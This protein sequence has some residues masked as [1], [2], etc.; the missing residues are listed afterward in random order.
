[1][2]ALGV[3]KHAAGV[4][5]AFEVGTRCFFVVGCERAR[6]GAD[7]SRAHGCV[8]TSGRKKEKT[9]DVHAVTRCHGGC[10]CCPAPLCDALRNRGGRP[11]M[12]ALLDVQA[13][14]PHALCA[15]CPQRTTLQSAGGHAG[16]WR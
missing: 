8:W 16:L 13:V 12:S 11:H 1:M 10:A 5:P 7:G 14:L 2:A 3:A 6:S 9:A 15:L 4:S